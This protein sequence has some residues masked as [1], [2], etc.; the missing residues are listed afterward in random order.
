M[1]TLKIRQVENAKAEPVRKKDPLMYA[2]SIVG[3]SSIELEGGLPKAY[4]ILAHH[5][6]YSWLNW[7][8]RAHGYLSVNGFS[9]ECHQGHLFQLLFGPAIKS[10][11]LNFTQKEPATP[12]RI[13]TETLLTTIQQMA[14]LTSP[15]KGGDEFLS[16]QSKEEL[17]ELTLLVA[18]ELYYRGSD[19]SSFSKT[20]FVAELIPQQERNRGELGIQSYGRAFSFYEIAE[21]QKSQSVAK[22]LELFSNAAGCDAEN[23][24]LGGMCILLKEVGQKR[25]HDLNN[26]TSGW[27]P[28]A[29]PP[30]DTHSKEHSLIM[31]F[32]SRKSGT[33][34]EIKREI[35]RHEGNREVREWNLIALSRFPILVAD[36]G[37]RFVLNFSSLS[38]TL[39]SGVYHTILSSLLKQ[40]KGHFNP[41][42]E[43]GND[44]G[45]VFENYVGKILQTVYGDRCIK[46]EHPGN[47]SR[48]IADY[49]VVSDNLTLIFE[50]KG[51]HFRRKDHFESL[52]IDDRRKE[53]VKLG[54]EEAFEQLADTVS[55]LRSY[56]WPIPGCPNI[57]WTSVPIIPVL[58]TDEH[59]PLFPLAWGTLYESFHSCLTELNGGQGT[60]CKARLLNIEELEMFPDLSGEYCIAKL[61]AEWSRDADMFELAFSNFLDSKNIRISSTWI[62]SR[63]TE[64]IQYLSDVLGLNW[65][66]SPS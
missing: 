37:S 49:L 43:L 21:T 54:V 59:L 64:A 15:L 24:I 61:L 50:T 39:F 13:F 4:E 17:G 66:P 5:S 28:V 30:S 12:H 42:Q 1:F 2:A 3:A 34:E 18:D 52:S 57:D 40:N 20:T 25:F 56:K 27:S 65:K 48:K 11:V 62:K 44:Y 8:A 45:E 53:L 14:I 32:L 38:D 35:Q 10:R 41:T 60:V 46:L 9:S 16:D 26:L 7:T 33:V 51:S 23:F 6:V 55:R 47:D 22:L 29:I 36:K 19:N 31:Q 63:S 58:V